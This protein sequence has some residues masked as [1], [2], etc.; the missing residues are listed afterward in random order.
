METDEHDTTLTTSTEEQIEENHED[1]NDN[2][3]ENNEV[4]FISQMEEEAKMR[5]V[6][7]IAAMLRR[8]EQ[9]EKVN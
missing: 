6:K 5:A 8:P 7:H 9:L 1:V 4:D 3:S 2:A